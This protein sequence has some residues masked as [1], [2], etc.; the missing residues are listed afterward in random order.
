MHDSLGH[1]LVSV[2]VKLEAAQRLYQV[3][4]GRGDTELEATRTLVRDTMATLRHSIA[5]LRAPLPDQDDLPA[6][7]RRLADEV[8]A[9]GAVAVAVADAPGGPPPA[10]PVAAAL[11]LIARE[12]L[13]NVE[14][15]AGATTAIVRV[16]RD[17]SGWALE[18]ADDGAGVH[19]GDLRRP[20]HFGVLG[21]RERAAAQNGI[22]QIAAGPAGGTRVVARIPDPGIIEP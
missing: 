6:A 19:P 8:S 11:V 10:P 4:A 20:G 1:A 9:R 22:L 13:V 14:R 21:M 15:H 18:V 7:L 16:S 12:A 2:N 5:D 3:D 17:A